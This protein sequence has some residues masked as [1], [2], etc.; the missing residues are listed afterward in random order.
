M[1]ALRDASTRWRARSEGFDLTVGEAASGADLA[2][3]VS[4]GAWDRFGL[5]FADFF[6]VY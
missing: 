5:F 2:A 3:L 4:D 6:I 1:A